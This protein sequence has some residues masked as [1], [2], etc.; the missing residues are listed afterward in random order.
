MQ[1]KFQPPPS[2]RLGGVWVDYRQTPQNSPSVCISLIP[3]TRTSS[4]V[5][6]NNNN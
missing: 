1:A 3:S 4:L 2:L 6:D 5:E